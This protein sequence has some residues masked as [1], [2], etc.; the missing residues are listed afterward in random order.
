MPRGATISASLSR[1]AA[2]LRQGLAVSR[3]FWRTH[4]LIF[5][6]YATP[7]AAGAFLAASA[8]GRRP[9][10]WEQA[11][12]LILPYVT[13]IVGTVVVMVAV[14]H[15]AHG[16]PIGVVKASLKAIPWVPR[17][18]WTNVHTTVIFWLPVG[19]LLAL[20]GWQESA[21]PLRGNLHPIVSVLWLI[22]IGAVALFMH[23]RTLLAPFF[24]IHGDLPGTLAALEAWRASGRRLPLCLFTLVVAGA[25]VAV[26]LGLVALALFFT[27][28]GQTLT[29]FVAAIG[30]LVWVG[31]QAIRPVLIPAIY[32]LYV[33]L[34]EVELVRRGREG[35]PAV[36]RLARPLLALTGPLPHP[37]RWSGTLTGE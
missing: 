5:L 1:A 20:R 12:M 8:A 14:S 33:D 28:T 2:Y 16:R 11:A 32:K 18:F 23:A 3:G 36:P 9:A 17:Y 24:A 6:V 10:G 35:A 7:A 13:A 29:A 37:G 19:L 15:Q 22:L 31:I 25:P 4:L 27:L 34:W 21:A 26:P 30:D